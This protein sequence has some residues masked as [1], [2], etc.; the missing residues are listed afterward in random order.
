MQNVMGSLIEPRL[1]GS[2]LSISPLL[3]L[4]SLVFWGWLW[5]VVGMILAVPIAVTI[6]IV[7]RHTPG[8]DPVSTMFEA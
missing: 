7:C 1:M 8:L 5:G 3:L 4:L 2:S 6:K